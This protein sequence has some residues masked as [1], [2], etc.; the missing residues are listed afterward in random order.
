MKGL[1]LCLVHSEHSETLA[2]VNFTMTRTS[3]KGEHTGG[4]GGGGGVGMVIFM[5]DFLEGE[6]FNLSLEG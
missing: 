3:E 5:N 4:G 2:I 6:E 1:T